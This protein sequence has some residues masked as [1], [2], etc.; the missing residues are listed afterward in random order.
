[1]LIYKQLGCKTAVN[2]NRVTVIIGNSTF[3]IPQKEAA[4]ATRQEHI[5]GY[6]CTAHLSLRSYIGIVC[7]IVR[8]K[9]STVYKER[10]F[11]MSV[12]TCRH[13]RSRTEDGHVRTTKIMSTCLQDY[14]SFNTQSRFARVCPNLIEFLA[15]KSFI[16]L[17]NEGDLI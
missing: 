12:E 9:T 6:T 15:V 4:S 14:A 10:D 3:G 16:I 13:A 17:L 2:D 8:I 7:E 1:M 11:T 5:I